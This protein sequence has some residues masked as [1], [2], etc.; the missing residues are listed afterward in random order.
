MNLLIL[1]HINEIFPTQKDIILDQ[2]IY[3]SNYFEKNYTEL[4]LR[5]RF[6]IYTEIN[7]CKCDIPSQGFKIHISATS[8]N[9]QE[10]L[11]IVFNYARNENIDFKYISNKKWLL[12]TISSNSERTNSGKFIT[13]YTLN[14]EHFVQT[15]LEL[16]KLLKHYEGPYILSDKRFKNTNIFYRYGK[17]ISDND[18]YLLGPNGEIV[19]DKRV[20]YFILPF[21]IKDPLEV[22]SVLQKPKYIGTKYKID[23]AITF[24]NSGGIYTGR[25]LKNRKIIIKEV[26]PFI[27]DFGISPVEDKNNEKKI[28]E[29]SSEA[30]QYFPN[31][32]DDFYDMGHYF[33]V[34]EYIEGDT[35]Q[36]I[37][38]TKTNFE[39]G[40]NENLFN[41]LSVIF[42]NLL[43]GLNT[44]HKSNIFL[45]D[46][47]DTNIIVNMSNQIFFIDLE[48]S[49]NL[50]KVN[51]KPKIIGRTPGFF[52]KN[53]E[54]LDLLEQDKQQ[55]GY[56]LLSLVTK[57]NF[58]LTL[59][60]TGDA[61]IGIF[62]EMVK[63]YNIPKHLADV[64]IQLI[65][66]K[67]IKLDELIIEM[68]TCNKKMITFTKKIRKNSI[69]N[70][71]MSS[72]HMYLSKKNSYSE[73]D[74]ADNSSSIYG[75]ASIEAIYKH[76][77]INFEDILL[78][79]IKNNNEKINT[80]NIS[81]LNGIS[82]NYIYFYKN[83]EDVY[84]LEKELLNFLKNFFEDEDSI[85]LGLFNGALGVVYA[86]IYTKK[87][88]Y[89]EPTQE[90][91][92]TF[93]EKYVDKIIF[94]WNMFMYKNGKDVSPYLS[95]GSSG[96]LKVLIKWKQVFTDDH[97]DFEINQIA[98][99]ISKIKY[100]QSCCFDTGIAGIIESLLDYEECFQT[101]KYSKSITSFFE[102]IS[103]FI[104]EVDKNYFVP[105]KN[106]V[107]AGIDYGGGS[108]GIISVYKRFSVIKG[109]AKYDKQPIF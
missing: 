58:L 48:N 98:D 72:S 81:L 40:R 28:L 23:K 69:E 54:K 41:F 63:E 103:N 104:I 90:F 13:I 45:G 56:L 60:P 102:Q 89:Q 73:P 67:D 32:I 3:P 21:F 7:F 17:I 46:I 44:I 18:N 64:V 1:N 31:Y 20:P 10:I 93:I 65:Y 6:G 19:E 39:D 92:I 95:N 24:K 35:L 84:I 29:L 9:Y 105:S 91:L 15:V 12:H 5:D 68:E 25:D 71:I 26:R 79:N 47:S 80:K 74:I 78:Y 4:T 14:N 100:P 109:D 16:E 30:K 53:I 37:R 33:L 87:K 59:D 99:S 34:E 106:F 50:S 27:E 107:S 82:N 94:P 49:I 108:G 22:N 66:N 11:D 61:T 83:N 42:T 55:M 43:K 97:F 75:E 38:S 96:L 62:L 52:N 77:L 76:K 36:R 88:I 85:D 86:L 101:T 2:D 8:G 70:L 51:K 57:S